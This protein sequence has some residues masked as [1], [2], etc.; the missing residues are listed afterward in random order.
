M[1]IRSVWPVIR[2]TVGLI[3]RENI[4]KMECQNEIGFGKV[5]MKY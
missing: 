3:C 1:I 2:Q 5:G 4:P